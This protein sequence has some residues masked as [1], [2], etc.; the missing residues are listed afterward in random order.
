MQ[1]PEARSLREGIT[2]GSFDVFGQLQNH[3]RIFVDVDSAAPVMLAV[4]VVNAPMRN[5][6]NT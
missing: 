2:T 4:G 5:T 6:S 1:S 3:L